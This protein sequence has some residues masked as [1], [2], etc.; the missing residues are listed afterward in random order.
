[1]KEKNKEKCPFFN[2]GQPTALIPTDL[3][4]YVGR[5]LGFGEIRL[6]QILYGCWT[7]V[8]LKSL[9]RKVSNSCLISIEPSIS[10]ALIMTRNSAFSFIV[11]FMISGV[12]ESKIRKDKIS[13]Q[14]LRLGENHILKFNLYVLLSTHYF[15]EWWLITGL[16][17]WVEASL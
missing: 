9:R 7:S 15:S 2:I 1:M 11:T 13:H 4:W 10:E 14:Q 6:R 8:F 16:L 3:S 5:L 12:R 17:V